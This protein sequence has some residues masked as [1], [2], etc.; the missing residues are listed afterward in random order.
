MIRHNKKLLALIIAYSVMLLFFLYG[1]T[2]CRYGADLPSGGS[3]E[4][5]TKAHILGTDDL[6]VDVYAQISKSFFRSMLIGVACASITFIIGGLMGLLSGFVGGK[7]DIIISFLINIVLSVPQLPIMIVL[8]VFL[9]QK[10]INIILIISAF[11]W[12]GI[13]KIIRAKT[14]T[15][16]K[17]PYIQLARSYGGSDMYIII[18]HLLP[19]ILPLLLIS[20]IA[21]IGSAIIK[22]SSLAFLGLSN[23]LARSWG[24]MISRATRFQGIFF[25]DFWKWWL[26]S[27]IISL[28]L[29]TTLL[30]L[31]SKELQRIFTK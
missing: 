24:I 31:I 18:R 3:L 14:I 10:T 21:I 5:P 19:Q 2:F 1:V 29:S 16:C 4:A 28:I 26:M 6:G 30:R 20:S 27:P 13:A 17:K 25:T 23:P 9:G 12:G 11:S 15:I 8:G 22:E 7:T